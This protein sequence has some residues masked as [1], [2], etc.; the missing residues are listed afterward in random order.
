MFLGNTAPLLPTW[1]GTISSSSAL[2]FS[3]KPYGYKTK[4]T[5]IRTKNKTTNQSN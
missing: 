5:R 4:E 3:Y 2:E 1:V